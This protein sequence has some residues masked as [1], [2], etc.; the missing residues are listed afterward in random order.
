MISSWSDRSALEAL[1]PLELAAYLRS[2]GWREVRVVP[3]KG[4]VWSTGQDGNAFEVLLPLNHGLADYLTRLHQVLETLALAEGRPPAEVWEDLTT[5]GADIVRAAVQRPDAEDGTLPL[6][7][8]V[9]LV[10]SARDLMLASACAAVRPRPYYATRK[11]NQALEYVSRLRLGQTGRGS[12]VVTILSRVPAGLQPAAGTDLFGQVEEPFD[13]RATAT[14]ARAL[15]AVQA[16]AERT[17]A[18]GR[19]DAFQA[20]IGTGVSANLCQALVDMAGEGSS[21]TGLQ[22]DFSWSPLRPV[23]EPLPRRVRVLADAL[24]IIREAGRILRETSPQEE[25]VLRGMVVRLDRPEGADAGTV[26]VVT[27]ID[28]RPRRVNVELRGSDY[29]Q[30][31]RAHQER[32]PVVC[33]GELIREGR[34]LILRNPRDFGLEAVEALF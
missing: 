12:Y 20:A 26:G 9:E 3:G 5:S 34:T 14:L 33:T 18:T 16:A 32:Q 25:F 23:S 4:S 27:Y 22:F 6:E 11:P 10:D 29:D 8:G 19:L 24:P 30:A 1:R 7:A 13:R 31:I 21:V 15:E 2:H 28:G 17:A